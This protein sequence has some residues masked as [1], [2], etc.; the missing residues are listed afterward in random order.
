MVQHGALPDTP[1]LPPSPPDLEAL[2]LD[3]GSA[4]SKS[5]RQKTT[6]RIA[7]TSDE[8]RHRVAE[9][10]EAA[11][12]WAFGL[13]Q[14]TARPALRI[15]MGVWA[16]VDP[17]AAFEAASKLGSSGADP[18]LPSYGLSLV[19][20]PWAAADPTAVFAAAK[21]LPAS[22]STS[23]LQGRIL[24]L[25]A[26]K[27]PRNAAASLQSLVYESASGAP[28]SWGLQSVVSNVAYRLAL[29]STVEAGEW[30]L[31]FPDGSEARANALS[32][33]VSG[34]I[35]NTPET[36]GKWL[37]GMTPG[38]ARDAGVLAVVQGYGPKAPES[39][40]AW[41]QTLSNEAQR[42]NLTAITA[43][44]WLSTDPAKADAWIR[45]ST[46][47]SDD[48]RTAIFEAHRLIPKPGFAGSLR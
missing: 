24:T 38:A 27:D 11:L 14:D 12:A 47:L 28:E 4:A 43:S 25:W 8:A 31:A 40:L 23:I 21:A 2:L 18:L 44:R 10:P 48:Q 22:P 35:D 13:D 15:V 5:E 41:A 3:A 46:V 33:V 42:S 16:K 37:D 30:A 34:W 36:V 17:A 1:P 32:G 29:K 7:K 9:D 20:E 39:A 6:A 45:T 26:E 19:V